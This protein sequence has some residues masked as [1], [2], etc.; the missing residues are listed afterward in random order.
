[1]PEPENFRNY[2]SARQKFKNI[3][4]CQ[5]LRYQTIKILLLANCHISSS[6]LSPRVKDTLKRK[7]KIPLPSH[8]SRGSRSTRKRSFD[9]SNDNCLLLLLLFLPLAL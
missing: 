5:S 9:L 2:N 6:L 8:F 7:I 3:K 1:M 4:T